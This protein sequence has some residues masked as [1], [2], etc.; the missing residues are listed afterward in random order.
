M[1]T[2]VLTKKSYTPTPEI[3]GKVE[4]LTEEERQRIEWALKEEALG[5]VVSNEEVMR[6]ARELLCQRKRK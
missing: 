6:E 5:L 2:E 3:E 1:G 4:K